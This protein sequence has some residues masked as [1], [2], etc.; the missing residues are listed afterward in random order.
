MPSQAWVWR[1]IGAPAAAAGRQRREMREGAGM[2]KNRSATHPET[3]FLRVGSPTT[4]FHFLIMSPCCESIKQLNHYF[5]QSPYDCPWICLTD[6]PT[7]IFANY[8]FL[9]PVKL[10]IKIS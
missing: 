1:D 4:V 8:V 6:R 3:L 9:S 7:G 2:G 5:G 10:A